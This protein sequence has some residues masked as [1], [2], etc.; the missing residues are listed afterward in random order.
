MC[1][2]LLANYNLL[3]HKVTLNVWKEEESPS[4]EKAI[5]YFNML[6]KPEL[7]HDIM[8]G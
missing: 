6:A 5:E 4:G 8:I 1:I 7:R 3:Q 2:Y